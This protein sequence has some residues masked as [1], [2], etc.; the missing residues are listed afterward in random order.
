MSESTWRVGHTAARGLIT[1]A[2]ETYCDGHGESRAWSTEDLADFTQGVLEAAIDSL[3]TLK[4]E[5]F[6]QISEHEASFVAR[7]MR[8]DKLP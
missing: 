5:N 7:Q 1:H 4:P 6:R 2:D 3:M 8:L